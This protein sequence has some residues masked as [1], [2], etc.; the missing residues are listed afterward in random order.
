MK[1]IITNAD[2][3]AALRRIAPETGS[4]ACLGCG[5]EHDCGIHGC[6]LLREAAERSWKAIRR[7]SFLMIARCQMRCRWC[8]GT[9]CMTARCMLAAWTGFTVVA[10]A[11]LWLARRRVLTTARG[12]GQGWTV[13]VMRLID[14]D[15]VLRRRWMPCRSRGAWIAKAR[16]S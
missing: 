12:A 16:G 3:A 6:A 5:Y 8:M 13:I 11:D 1:A 10:A 4:L 2:L 7:K 9:L 14:A 15:A